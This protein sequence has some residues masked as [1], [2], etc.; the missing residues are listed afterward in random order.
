VRWEGVVPADHAHPSDGPRRKETAGG[1]RSRSNSLAP[2]VGGARDGG[3]GA[4]GVDDMDD[5][6]SEDD[7]GRYRRALDDELDLPPVSKWAGA[8]RAQAGSSSGQQ[9]LGTE[10]VSNMVAD[11]EEHSEFRRREASGGIPTRG[12]SF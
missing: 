8:P 9:R 5:W 7:D 2:E 1:A 12:H 3:L 4:A 6:L 10:R 11:R